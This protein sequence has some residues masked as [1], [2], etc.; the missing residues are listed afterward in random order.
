MFGLQG[1][2]WN[3]WGVQPTSSKSTNNQILF[4]KHILEA[5]LEKMSAAAMFAVDSLRVGG[6]EPLHAFG[7]IRPLGAQ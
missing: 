7:K 2:S 4:N 6:S 3:R 5:A 1:L